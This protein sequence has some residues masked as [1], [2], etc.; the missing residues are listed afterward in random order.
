MVVVATAFSVAWVPQF[1]VRFNVPQI[2]M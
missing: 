1:Q 2:A